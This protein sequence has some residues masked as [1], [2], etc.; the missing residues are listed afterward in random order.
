MGYLLERLKAGRANTVTC[1]LSG[2]GEAAVDAVAIRLLTAQDVLEAA[3]AADQVFAA[4]GVAVSSKPTRRRRT[5]NT[6]TGPVR[7]VRG[8]RSR[9]T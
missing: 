9:Q 3:L 6:S 4:A 1:R 7:T 8:S 5:F 2:A